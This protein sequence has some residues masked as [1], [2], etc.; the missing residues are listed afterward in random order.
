M[1]LDLATMLA[2]MFHIPVYNVC[3]DVL[4]RE[5]VCEYIFIE[6]SSIHIVRTMFSECFK[7]CATWTTCTLYISFLMLKRSECLC[8]YSIFYYIL[9]MHKRMLEPN[10]LGRLV[11]VNE[12][13]CEC[14]G[15]NPK[16][17][18]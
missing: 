9:H 2:R 18:Y 4:L 13:E 15:P 11:R 3:I 5:P 17:Q 8:V 7:C 6:F 1:D 14:I 10:V 16:S 12:Y